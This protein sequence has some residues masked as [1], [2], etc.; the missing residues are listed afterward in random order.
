[1]LKPSK[2]F[3]YLTKYV[4]LLISLLRFVRCPLDYNNFY[5]FSLIIKTLI[6]AQRLTDI[7]FY[8]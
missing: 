1:M 6:I 5:S 4:S 3:K 2:T 7:Y 8:L